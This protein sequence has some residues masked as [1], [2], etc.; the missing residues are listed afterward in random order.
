MN[1]IRKIFYIAF[2]N[3]L[4]WNSSP[5]VLIIAIL[6]TLIINTNV[7]GIK[8][9]SSSV[10]IPARPWL[11]PFLTSDWYILMLL[12]FLVI[13]LFCDAPFID[14]HQPYIII[15]SKRTIWMLGQVLYIIFSSALFFL[16]III[17]SCILMLP[18][19]LFGN[20]WGAIY[21]TLSQTN[22]KYDFSIQL[23]FPYRILSSYNPIAAMLW[24][25]ILAWSI[26]IFIGLIMLVFNFLFNRVIGAIIATAF[27]LLETFTYYFAESTIYYFSPISWA[28]LLITDST[29]TSPNPSN[30]FAIITLV[31][32]NG[33]LIIC[34]II[35][36]NRR[37]I[38]VSLQ[39]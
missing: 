30:W 16:F 2:Q 1:E 18:N 14:A 4:K 10:H 39:I 5:K 11:F 12:S 15:R 31:I 36:A 26:G 9:F 13:L 29:N 6:S 19:I 3:I 35:I 34:S 23:N 38:D 28:N 27:V 17:V 37:N 24:S 32:L 33:I 8:H 7:I 25:F 22:V 21:K 20:D